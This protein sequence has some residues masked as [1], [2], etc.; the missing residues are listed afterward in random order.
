MLT[1]VLA[2]DSFRWEHLKLILVKCPNLEALEIET[3]RTA[4]T[5]RD[6]QLP[7]SVGIKLNR[8]TVT[9]DAGASLALLWKLPHVRDIETVDIRLAGY[10]LPRVAQDAVELVLRALPLLAA[11]TV[12]I[13]DRTLEVR[14]R[15]RARDILRRLQLWDAARPPHRTSARSSSSA[16]RVRFTTSLWPTKTALRSPG[17]AR[18]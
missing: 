11:A 4:Y 9:V 8:L 2:G 10:S 12:R 17:C 18:C 5:L 6:L 7:R 14:G 13:V 16:P 1:A 15:S 3:F